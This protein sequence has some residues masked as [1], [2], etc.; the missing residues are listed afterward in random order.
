MTGRRGIVNQPYGEGRFWGSGPIDPISD[1]LGINSSQSSAYDI[2]SLANRKQF[3][4]QL[5]GSSATPKNDAA[6]IINTAAKKKAQ[7]G[8]D[9]AIQEFRKNSKEYQEIE[10][11]ID[12]TQRELDKL[13]RDFSATIGAQQKY[14]ILQQKLLKTR[15]KRFEVL[16]KLNLKEVLILKF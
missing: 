3:L 4:E 5:R 2:M 7:P 11:E 12:E 16:E 10:K 14:D 15:Q 13:G 9:K 1:A 6:S 8:Y